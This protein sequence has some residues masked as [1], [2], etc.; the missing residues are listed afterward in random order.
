[1]KHPLE[2][3]IPELRAAIRALTDTAGA[4]PVDAVRGY[5]GRYTEADWN[6]LTE[7][8]Y[9]ALQQLLTAY[10]AACHAEKIGPL[11]GWVPERSAA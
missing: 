5:L 6:G 8:E 4:T 1:M 7:V 2:L 9:S 11:D 3:T 10:V